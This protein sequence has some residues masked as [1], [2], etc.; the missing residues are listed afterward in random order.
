MAIAETQLGYTESTKN[1]EVL[2]D[3]ETIRGYTRYGAW[4]G[5]PYG[6]WCAMFVSFCLHYAQTEEIP[7]NGGCTAWVEALSAENCA[8]YREADTYTP[9][10]GDL[11]FF[12][13]KEDDGAGHVGLVVEMIEATED[14]PAK[15]K[16]IEGNSAEQVQK[17]TYKL[18]DPTILGYGDLTAA[19]ENF[20]A[21]H[22][23]VR[24]VIELIDEMPSADEIDAQLA[25]FGA[26]EDYEGEEAWYTG[27]V[28]Q[29]AMVY[30]YY[31]ELSDEEKEL[32]I[33]DDKLL[34]LEY[35]W[36]VTAYLAD[37]S[38]DKPTTTPSASTS[39]FVD[40]NLYDYSGNINDNYS[41]ENKY[42]GFQWNGGAYMRGENTYDRHVI[43]FIDFGNSF[44][45]D[46][47]YGSKGT[48]FKN[49]YS[50][51][52]SIVGK[53]N[54]SNGAINALDVSEYGVTNRPIGMS[55][56]SSITDTSQDVLSRTLGIDGYP[57]LTD[58]TS[59]SYLF[60]NG[61]YANKLNT[62]SIDGL[63]KQDAASGEYYYNSRWNHAQYSNNKFALYNQIITPNFIT[64][65]FG[66]FLPLNDITNTNNAT[67]VGKITSIGT[68]VQEVINDM[69]Y[70]SSLRSQT[71][72]TWYD[73]T[74]SQLVDMLVHYRADLQSI[75]TSSSTAWNT[76]SAKDAIV[77]YF[78]TGDSAADHPSDDTS[79]ITTDLLNKMYNIDW[80]VDTNFFF[81]MDMTMNFIQPKG[82]MTGN[83]TNKD[84]ES[85]YPMVFYFTGD[86]D[87]WVYIDGV[88]FLDLSGI[89]RHVGGEI[90]FVKGVVKYYYLDTKNTGDV[91]TTPYK[92]YTFTEILKAAGKST[93]GLNSNGT[94]AD[95][96]A[97]QFK[98]YYMYMERG[99]GSSVCRLNFNFPL[100][101][102]NS[103]SVSKEVSSDTEILGNP[104]Y[105]F[106]VLQADSSG[107][108][109]NT[110]FITAGTGYT[111]YDENDNKIGTGIT[112][113]NGVFTLKAGQ[114][115]EFTEI[116]ENAGKYYV[117]ELLE[118][119][120]LEQY[121]NVTVSGESATTSNNVTVGSDT[122]TGM[123]S[124]V[125]DMSDGA[126]AFRFTND[127]DEDNLGKL[128]ISKVLT[129]YSKTRDVKYFNIEVTLDGEKLPV[130]TKYTVGNETRTV[131]TAGIIT[132]AA[133][134]TATI[135][136]ILAGTAFTVQETNSHR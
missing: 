77:D 72:G 55:R 122:F 42:P 65:P 135:A 31:S 29:V 12:N 49:G 21:K 96:T 62:S 41:K 28:Q 44:I 14:E 131:T 16:V 40:L 114:R 107:N 33:N 95:Y 108:K 127:V 92:T 93:D 119:T 57:A 8:L 30:H 27:I 56:N 50:S 70:D 58:G 15:I 9:Q 112:D 75:S 69:W 101:R 39:E 117:R 106:Q 116:P 6:D 133:D 1:Y 90:D 105:S 120:V 34:E 128:N 99:S 76:W 3:G 110:L 123:D 87:V 100:L 32:V 5:N 97:H 25:E 60:V 80:D 18:N 89:H 37:I 130:G 52:R 79:L 4:Y 73:S 98:F 125:K 10:P 84:D 45:T 83:D 81:G 124:P 88:L 109:T 102:Q 47:E 63:F 103:I 78:T 53:S 19:S 17:V 115:A 104:D 66:N 24:N 82:G 134:E 113:A 20:Y 35:I 11:I 54:G 126:T 68:Y 26:T 64:Y 74:A 71:S 38:S 121:G 48:T 43:D 2:E 67:Q 7:L 86:D 136:N 61:I 85:D 91:S 111:I 13:I 59:L 118:G 22:P 132:I 129:E 36:S 23:E 51:N 46:F 94:F